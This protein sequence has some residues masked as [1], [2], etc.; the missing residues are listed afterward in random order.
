MPTSHRCDPQRLRTQDT[1]RIG[2]VLSRPAGFPIKQRG[3]EQSRTTNAVARH[4]PDSEETTKGHGRKAPSGQRYTKTTTLA[5]DDSDDVL[6]NN[7]IEAPRP[8]KKERT[9]FYRVLD[10][11]EEA[12]QKIYTDQPGRFP[13][14][15]SRGNQYIMV[16]NEVDSDAILIE[17]MKNRTAGEMIRAYQVLIDRLNS[18]GI[19]PKHHI[20]D[21]ECSTELKTVIKNN[22]MTFQLVPPHRN[23]AEKAI[24]TFK[25]HF[26]SILC[27]ADKMFP[28]HLWD[29]LLRQAEHT[30]NMLRPSRMTPT[31]SAY[32]YLWKQHD[33]NAN[34]FA[35]LGCKVEAHLVPSI[36]E[37]WAPHTASGFYIGNAWDHYRCHEIYITDTRHARVCNTVFFKHIYLTMPTI[38]PADALIRAADDLTD[39]L[40]GVVPPPNMTRDAVDQLMRIFKEQAEKAKDDATTQRVLKER[41]RDERV[42]NE[43]SNQ[44]AI[45]SPLPPLEVTYPATL[46]LARYEVPLSYHWMMMTSF[47]PHPRPTL[48]SNARF[49]PSHKTTCIT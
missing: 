6:G 49:A 37:S 25:D 2:P 20:L 21:N 18:A 48:V 16:L 31:I 5:L 33:Y 46:M 19:F 29:R 43:V 24:Q 3:L 32:T 41:T 44:P 8:R 14:K 39:T 12:A 47:T 1:T 27:G 10:M 23:I 4:Y 34:P 17:L 7:N 26:I 38:T 13:K 35:P 9:V 11:N 22:K 30:L 28:L 36:R 42:H 40:T 15:S 45:P